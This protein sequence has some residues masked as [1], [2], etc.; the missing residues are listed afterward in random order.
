MCLRSW[1]TWNEINSLLW[2]KYWTSYK[3][4]NLVKSGTRVNELEEASWCGWD[5]ILG[6]L[7][8][9]SDLF[10]GNRAKTLDTCLLFDFGKMF[11]AVDVRRQS[12]YTVGN[13]LF[14]MPSF[15]LC[16]S[17]GCKKYEI[18]PFSLRFSIGPLRFYK[19]QLLFS[20]IIG[21]AF[22]SSVWKKI[23][24]HIQRFLISCC[25]LQPRNGNKATLYDISGLSSDVRAVERVTGR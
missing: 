7:I 6:F 13:L 11:W 21:F 23:Q 2:G 4:S 24:W 22:T 15:V 12:C 16:L 25:Y 19:V 9:F 14:L 3:G 20:Y 10:F 17:Y 18:G 8:N 5:D 1:K